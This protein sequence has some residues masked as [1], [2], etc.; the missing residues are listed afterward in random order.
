FQGDVG[1]VVVHPGLVAGFLLA[2]AALTLRFAQHLTGLGVPVALADAGR[3][4]AV[5]EAVLF[6]AADRDLDDLISGLADDG[7]LGNE[8]GDVI[9]NRLAH[10]LAVA[11]TVTGAAVRTQRVRW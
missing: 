7:F 1:L 5:D 2:L 8:V 10:L 4:L 3:I 6:H 11:L 9:A